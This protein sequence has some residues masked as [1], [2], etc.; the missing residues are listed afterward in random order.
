[1]TRA[2]AHAAGAMLRPITSAAS[3]AQRKFGVT[4]SYSGQTPLPVPLHDPVK[5]DPPPPR[6]PC[7]SDC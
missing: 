2:A 7:M 6:G 1:M 5:F 3:I 4:P